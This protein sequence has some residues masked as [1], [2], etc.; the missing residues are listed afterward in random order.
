MSFYSK[1]IAHTKVTKICSKLKFTKT[2]VH[3]YDLIILN[4]PQSL[5][6]FI[7]KQIKS[8][9]V[10][11]PLHLNLNYIILLA[12]KEPIKLLYYQPKEIAQ[13]YISQHQFDSCAY[14][15]PNLKGNNKYLASI[16]N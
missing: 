11:Y 8:L 9:N 3:K 7:F 13:Y 5:H 1:R 15:T 4:G 12:L 6:I 2:A 14:Y 10:S 16:K